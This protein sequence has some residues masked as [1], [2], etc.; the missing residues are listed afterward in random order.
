MICLGN[1]S[2]WPNSGIPVGA[3]NISR[4]PDIPVLVLEYNRRSGRRRER[5]RGREGERERGRER[6]RG[7]EGEKTSTTTPPPPPQQQQH[8]TGSRRL[9]AAKGEEHLNMANLV[10]QLYVMV[11]RAIVQEIPEV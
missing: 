8:R 11:E 9:S 4:G 3:T 2:I 7:R 5:E 1:E 10:E 6:Q